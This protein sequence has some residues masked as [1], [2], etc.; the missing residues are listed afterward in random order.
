[1]TIAPGLGKQLIQVQG[2]VLGIQAQLTLKQVTRRAAADI[3]GCR[4][5]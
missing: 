1:M 3:L 5:P 2:E 4:A